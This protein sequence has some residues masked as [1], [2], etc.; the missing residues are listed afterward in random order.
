MYK[1]NI[2]LSVLVVGVVISSHLSS[3][4]AENPTPFGEFQQNLRTF[5][6]LQ[7]AM[8]GKLYYTQAH[9]MLMLHVDA[10]NEKVS[11]EAISGHKERITWNEGKV[12]QHW[13]QLDAPRHL[14]EYDGIA[15]QLW[16]EVRSGFADSEL[17]SRLFLGITNE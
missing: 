13:V 5:S 9:R 1:K 12:F 17:S 3:V 10:E 16:T 6:R 7:V 15:D 14:S 4:S 11:L 2:L 8:D